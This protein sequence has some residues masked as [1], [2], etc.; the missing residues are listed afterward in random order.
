MSVSSKSQREVAAAERALGLILVRQPHFRMHHQYKCRCREREV[1]EPLQQYVHLPACRW[2]ITIYALDSVELRK[3]E[4][5]PQGCTGQSILGSATYRT[6]QV[7]TYPATIAS[8]V[9]HAHEC[10]SLICRIFQRIH[11]PTTTVQNSC[12][13]IEGIL[14]MISIAIYLTRR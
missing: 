3:G 8:L 4:S 1:R 9:C 6:S 5:N 13:R 10:T 11:G 2:K 7:R 14:D 12:T